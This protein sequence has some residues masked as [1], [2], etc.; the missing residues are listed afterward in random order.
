M[1]TGPRSGLHSKSNLSH[2]FLFAIV[3]HVGLWSHPF[4]SLGASSAKR[5]EEGAATRGCSGRLGLL[6]SALLRKNTRAQL[7]VRLVPLAMHA[8]KVHLGLGQ[9]LPESVV[10]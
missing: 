5:T 8:R 4:L 10:P 6:S 2:V 1:N 9:L 7:R 3:A